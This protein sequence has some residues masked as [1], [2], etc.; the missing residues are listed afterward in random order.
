MSKRVLIVDDDPDIVEAEKLILESRGYHVDSATDGESGLAKAMDSKP[1]LI[2]L[3]V[4]MTTM[5]E[6]IR[7]AQQ[8][9]RQPG[10]KHVPIIITTAIGQVTSLRFSPDDEILPVDAFVEKPVKPSHLIS[11]AEALMGGN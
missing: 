1:D 10:L 5:D 2:I 6:G 11:V 9:R 4:M 7:V 8:L 3:D